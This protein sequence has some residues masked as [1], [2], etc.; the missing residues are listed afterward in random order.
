MQSRRLV[1]ESVV[2]GPKGVLRVSPCEVFPSHRVGAHAS[3]RLK[4]SETRL[5]LEPVAW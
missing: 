1:D 2:L 4:I 5:G 3:P